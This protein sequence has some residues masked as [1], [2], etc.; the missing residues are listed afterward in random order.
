MG[1][2]E[3][4]RFRAEQLS[5]ILPMAQIY[6]GLFIERGCVCGGFVFVVV[7]HIQSLYCEKDNKL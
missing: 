4:Y 3:P 7:E 1:D 5:P 2:V 6:H